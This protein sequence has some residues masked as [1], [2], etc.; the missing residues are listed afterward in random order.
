MKTKRGGGGQGSVEHRGW[1]APGV[2]GVAGRGGRGR[3]GESGQGQGARRGGVPAVPVGLVRGLARR[4]LRLPT[5]PFH[6]E[7]VRDEVGRICREHGL[8]CEEDGFGNV[9]VTL[10][11]AAAGR[12]MVLAAHLDHPGF[13]VLGEEGEGVWRACF[14]GG[15]PDRYFRRGTGVRLYPGG[16]RARLGERLEGAKEYRLRGLGPV[17]EAPRFAVWDV[18]PFAVREGRVV[19]RG[20]DDVMGCA[21]ALATL[22]HLKRVRARVR[23]WA[24]LS[25]AEEVGFYGALALAGRGGLSRRALVVSLETSREMPPVAM[26]EGPIIR[27]GDRS[28][29]FDGAATRFLGEVAEE[30][31]GEDARFKYQRALMSGG[32]CEATAYGEY[33]YQATGLCVALGNYH[34]CGPRGRIAAEYVSMEDVRGMVRLLAAAAVAMPRFG[35]LTGRLRRRLERLRREA[36]VRLGEHS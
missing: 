14:L 23:V 6:E 34:N 22:V 25:R 28:T 31:R 8:G 12:P 9:R 20:C 33:G 27:V 35:G 30:V 13:E 10:E 2:V 32:T 11:T 3:G 15:V 4:L 1:I 7:A 21:A 19:A 24:V 5:A 29:V 17:Q 36:L 26:G 16:V 18:E